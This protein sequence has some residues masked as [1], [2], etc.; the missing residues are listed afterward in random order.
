[1]TNTEN[2]TSNYFFI[3]DTEQYAGNFEREMCAYCTGQ[4]G[5]CGVGE[6]E[7]EEFRSTF[8]DLEEK[9]DE[10]IDFLPDENGCA[11]PASIYP[12]PGWFNNGFGDFHDR[13]ENM[14]RED[15][16]ASCIKELTKKLS[17]IDSSEE[18]N[19]L[20]EEYENRK[21]IKY[22]AYLS[23]VIFFNE[24]PTDKIITIMKSRAHEFAQNRKITV[25]G[26]RLIKNKAIQES[27]PC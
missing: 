8:P 6:E 12:T 13:R 23:V 21:F 17:N 7:A 9:F 10:I 25:T 27:L 2:F 18:R 5:D 15:F 11:R 24:K 20:A 22:P 26:F 14:A 19:I 3:I 16:E 1:M 4:I